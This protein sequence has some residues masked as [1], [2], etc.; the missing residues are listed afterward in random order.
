[1]GL[2]FP[3]QA[4]G[5]CHKRTKNR[6]S[7]SPCSI[8]RKLTTFSK[9]QCAEICSLTNR[10]GLSNAKIN[11]PLISG[12]WRLRGHMYSPVYSSLSSHENSHSWDGNRIIHDLW[13]CKTI[14][15]WI[16]NGLV[17][18]SHTVESFRRWTQTPEPRMR[19]ALFFF[20]SVKRHTNMRQV[21]FTRM[22]TLSIMHCLFSFFYFPWPPFLLFFLL[23]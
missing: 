14:V 12:P 8:K 6:I 18:G 22:N 5:S 11:D 13:K 16:T 23:F 19:N 9:K 7:T 3:V 10:V 15:C 21:P 4:M 20:L 2:H 1:M 17:M